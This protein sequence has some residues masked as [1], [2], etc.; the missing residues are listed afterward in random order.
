M[1]GKIGVNLITNIELTTKQKGYL[2]LLYGVLKV[3]V[4]PF[5]DEEIDL[6]AAKFKKLHAL[7]MLRSLVMHT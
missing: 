5:G 3:F 6:Q 2:C 4:A 7:F 1:H